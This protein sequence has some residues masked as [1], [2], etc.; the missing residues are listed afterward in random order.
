MGWL[1]APGVVTCALALALAGAETL[2]RIVPG[3]RIE[4]VRELPG[5]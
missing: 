5:G 4:A 3:T 1:S 2:E